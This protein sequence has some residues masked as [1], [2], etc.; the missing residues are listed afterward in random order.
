[1][2]QYDLP[3]D[4]PVSV[5]E[6]RQNGS[7]LEVTYKGGEGTIEILC[8]S[9]YNHEDGNAGGTSRIYKYPDT[10]KEFLLG[11]RVCRVVSVTANQ[12]SFEI[13]AKK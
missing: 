2:A 9:R 8:I 3:K 1:M 5:K 10:T 4:T 7:P 13:L 6:M 12:L 11:R